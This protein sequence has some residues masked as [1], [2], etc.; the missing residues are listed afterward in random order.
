MSG[1]L[2]TFVIKLRLDQVENSLSARCLLVPGMSR[3]DSPGRRAGI[4]QQASYRADQTGC[5]NGANIGIVNSGV[6][7]HSVIFLKTFK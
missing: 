7:R 2:L 5:R 1:S 4:F 3:Q 6:L